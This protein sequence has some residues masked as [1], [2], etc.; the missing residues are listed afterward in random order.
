MMRMIIPLCLGAVNQ[1]EIL[2]ASKGQTPIE[3]SS[4]H[5]LIATFSGRQ[6]GSRSLSKGA[7]PLPATRREQCM[8]SSRGHDTRDSPEQQGS[9]SRRSHGLIATKYC[10]PRQRRPASTKQSTAAPFV[11]L[12]LRRTKSQTSSRKVL[13]QSLPP[14]HQHHSIPASGETCSSPTVPAHDL[15][16]CGLEAPTSKCGKTKRSGEIGGLHKCLKNRCPINRQRADSAEGGW[17]ATGSLH[18]S[19]RSTTRL[20][21]RAFC[22]APLQAHT[23]GN[24]FSDGG[25]TVKMR[26]A[27]LLLTRGSQRWRNAARKCSLRFLHVRPPQQSA[28]SLRRRGY[29]YE[30]FVHVRLSFHHWTNPAQH[31]LHQELLRHHLCCLLFRGL[32]GPRG[33]GSLHAGKLL[34]WR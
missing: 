18:S 20:V 3:H 10:A 29:K 26:S 9:R 6:A 14:P 23:P 19:G 5:L 17:E 21:T 15:R 34:H 28:K 16:C 30:A 27:V 25:R 7:L 12:S 1:T 11:T 13:T 33:R 4:V 22:L 8:G 2:H 31:A 32:V 24:R